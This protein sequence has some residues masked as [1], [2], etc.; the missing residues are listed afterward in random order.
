MQLHIPSTMFLNHCDIPPAKQNSRY[1]D[2]SKFDLRRQSG[3]VAATFIDVYFEAV[4]L[5]FILVL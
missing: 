4:E 3:P 5:K 1:V 2:H